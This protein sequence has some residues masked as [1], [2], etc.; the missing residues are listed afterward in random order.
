M[1]LELSRLVNSAS[2]GN[3]HFVGHILDIHNYP[4]PAMP[5][6]DLFGQ[7]QILVWGEYGGLGPQ[8][9]AAAFWLACRWL[10]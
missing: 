1:E 8:H 7:D 2:G 6:A 3:F 5:R 9:Q 10:S 4:N